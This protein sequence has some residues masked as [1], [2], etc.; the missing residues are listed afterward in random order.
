[1]S[2][3]LVGAIGFDVEVLEVLDKEDKPVNVLVA[4]DSYCSHSTM[5]Q[6]MADTLRLNLESLGPVSV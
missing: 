3:S 4:C 1:M 6:G 5:D 2:S